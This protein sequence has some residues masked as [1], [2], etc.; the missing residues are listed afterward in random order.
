M[1]VESEGV[2]M[3]LG[4]IQLALLVTVICFASAAHAQ[5]PT[6]A[7]SSACPNS[8]SVISP[9][10]ATPDYQCAA[11]EPT[12]AGDALQVFFCYDNTGN[13][14]TFTISDSGGDAFALVTTSATVGGKQCRIYASSN[15]AAGTRWVNAHLNSGGSSGYWQ[16]TWQEFYNVAASSIADASVCNSGNSTSV[17]AGSLGTLANSGDLIVQTSYST[18]ASAPAQ[19]GEFSEGSGFALLFQLIGDGAAAQY[20]VYNS[21]T[22]LTPTFTQATAIPYISCAV[23]MKAGSSGSAPTLYPRV[24]H[25]E[26]DAM[27]K[28]M[29]FQPWLVGAVSTADAVYLTY[30]SNDGPVTSN[31]IV[32][33][34]NPSQGWTAS[35]AN[36]VGLNGHNSTDIYAASFSSPPGPFSISITRN[37]NQNDGVFM[38]Y[39]VVGGTATLDVDSGGQA[40]VQTNVQSTLTVC[41]SCLTPTH[42]NDFIVQNSGQEWCTSTSM[43]APSG[44][45][46]LFDGAFFLGTSIDGPSQVGE[47]NAFAHGSNGSSLSPISITFGETCGG[48]NP[49]VQNWAGRVAAYESM[50][51]G[52]TP[53]TP[54]TGL[55]AIV[56]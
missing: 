39:D 14:Q 32:S 25:L 20:E 27:P 46:W 23:A 56:K 52:T 5:V 10:S 53:P 6:L 18:S 43:T 16:V 2:Q 13:N 19:T 4:I 45:D 24:V 42:Q 7:W 9:F 44:A 31:P 51:Q 35:G 55:V 3:K 17:S 30:L 41:N 37:N 26:M 1:P 40:G 29:F 21:A 22:A 49:A 36:F 8:G 34:P 11:A 28:N 33:S 38:V 47:N 48:S 50:S 54:P 12:T 15:I